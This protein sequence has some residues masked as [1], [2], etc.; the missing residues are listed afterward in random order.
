MD[1]QSQE[2]QLSLIVLAIFITFLLLLKPG[3]FPLLITVCA[4]E[5]RNELVF[6]SESVSDTLLDPSQWSSPQGVALEGTRGVRLLIVL[7]RI[8]AGSG[9]LGEAQWL[10]PK[11][12]WP[13]QMSENSRIGPRLSNKPI[14]RAN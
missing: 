4:V 9:H 11:M 12:N 6:K 7:V 2:N 3:F 5:V 14:T 13:P 1:T 10:A 8:V